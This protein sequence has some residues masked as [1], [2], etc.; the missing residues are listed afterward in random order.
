MNRESLRIDD[1]FLIAID[2]FEI[3]LFF[4]LFFQNV[5]ANGTEFSLKKEKGK[6]IDRII[7]KT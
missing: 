7:N 3:Y 6:K 4:F 5:S 1:P 2:R